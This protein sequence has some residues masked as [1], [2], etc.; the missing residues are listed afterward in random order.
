VPDPARPTTPPSPSRA[1][2]IRRFR[3]LNKPQVALRDGPS[4][5]LRVRLLRDLILMS[6]RSSLLEGWP[7]AERLSA[8]C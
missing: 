5:L 1:A 4:A 8:T 2:F 6:E 7:L 3:L